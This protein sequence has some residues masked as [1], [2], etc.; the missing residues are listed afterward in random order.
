MLFNRLGYA[1]HSMIYINTKL[2][3]QG[4]I[5]MVGNW[6][7]I[8]SFLFRASISDK[9]SKFNKIALYQQKLSTLGI[10]QS[11]HCLYKNQNEGIIMCMGSAS[12]RRRYIVTT[13]LIG[14]SSTQNDP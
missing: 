13:S 4:I 3:S 10:H 1:S 2:H 6:G 7:G 14:W 12:E 11:Y 8:F 9:I 5:L